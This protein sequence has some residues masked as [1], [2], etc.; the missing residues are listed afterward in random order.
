MQNF[1][2]E[3][4]S[5]LAG[6]PDFLR[7]PALSRR[8]AE[9]FEMGPEER[10]QVVSDALEA[11]HRVPFPDFARLLGTWLE[12]MAAMPPARREELFAEY[13]R[14]AAA[15]PGLLAPYNM[16]GM[17]G[18]FAGI[19]EEHREALAGTVAS[20]AARLDPEQRRVLRLV[21]PDAASEALGI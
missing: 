7:R 9:F 15:R 11:G 12:A 18:V 16:D 2:A 8:L 17:M 13:V 20:V 10:S 3:I 1:A 19:G 4:I 21:V 6:M 14:Q 5:S